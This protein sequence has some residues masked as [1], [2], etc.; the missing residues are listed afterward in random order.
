MVDFCL[1]GTQTNQEMMQRFVESLKMEEF[2][3]NS[4]SQLKQPPTEVLLVWLGSIFLFTVMYHVFTLVS[5]FIFGKFYAKFNELQKV[6]W[7][8]RL[9]SSVHALALGT[10]GVYFFFNDEKYYKDLD[11]MHGSWEGVYLY[12][13]SNGYFMVD[14]YFVYK[15][16]PKLG[17]WSMVFHHVMISL[18]QLVS[19]VCRNINSFHMIIGLL[20]IYNFGIERLLDR[21]YY[22][23]CQYEM[24]FGSCRI[25][26]G[27]I[28][29]H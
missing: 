27:Q 26:R 12:V 13:F 6:E 21:I 24:A 22:T 8:N 25:E 7:N 9:V 4:I 2:L 16:F 1:R 19:V 5:P 29:C 18:I 20:A 28:V 15:Y 14:S 11:V 17:G 10:F 23:L 3:Q